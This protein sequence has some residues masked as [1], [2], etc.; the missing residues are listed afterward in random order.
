MNRS[1]PLALGGRL[2]NRRQQSGHG[3]EVLEWIC[4][5]WL[6]FIPPGVPG[7]TGEHQLQKV[8]Y[9]I[10]SFDAAFHTWGL[11]Q[12]MARVNH[13]VDSPYINSPFKSSA[14]RFPKILF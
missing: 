1:H 6:G 14:S 7:R 2:Y 13:R 4:L 12:S 5:L 3:R 8:S 9:L 11:S 10:A